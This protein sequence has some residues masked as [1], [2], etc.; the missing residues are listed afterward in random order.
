MKKILIIT[1]R[2]LQAYFDSLMAYIL[3]I[4]FL[5]FSGF[6]TW[7]YG[8]DIFFIKQATLMPFFS[9][10]YWTL[11]FFIPALTMRLLSE[12][13]SLGTI[14][15][16]LTKPISNWQVIMGKFT[17]SL[18]LIIVALI[19]T[20]PYVI[21][22]TTIGN[23]DGGQVFSGYVALILFSSMMIGIGL[24]TSSIGNN[25]IVSYLL[26]LFIG[27]FFQIIFQMLGQNL[28]GFA[29]YL[30]NYL[31]TSSHFE[32]M[33]RGVIDSRDVLFFIGITFLSLVFTEIMLIKKRYV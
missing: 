14:E 15:L 24:F 16:L 8:S 32:S 31:S 11:F 4:L 29:G 2:E 21:S 17:A 23:V 7:I 33:T 26:A 1:K 27:I 5:G 25:Q 10:A 28:F 19:L 6:F 3:L 9:I 18:L 13:N 20:L 22:L 12:E 30:L